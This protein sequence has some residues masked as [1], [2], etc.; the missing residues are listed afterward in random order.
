MAHRTVRLIEIVIAAVAF[1]VRFV[2][3]V[4]TP[5]EIAGARIDWITIQMPD[6]LPR[7]RFSMKGKSHEPVNIAGINLVVPIERYNPVPS[8]AEMQLADPT[9]AVLPFARHKR[10]GSHLPLVGH[11]VAVFPAGDRSPLL[12][13]G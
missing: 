1:D 12:F 10:E 11:L 9:V 5:C 13:D 6:L 4:A 7:L 2:F 3:L 8:A